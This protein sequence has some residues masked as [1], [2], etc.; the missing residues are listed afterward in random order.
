MSD[1]FIEFE[2]EEVNLSIPD[3]FERQVFR[4]PDRIAVRTRKARLSYAKLNGLANSIAHLVISRGNE[5]NEPVALL[6]E[7]DA[8]LIAAIIGVLKAGR[9]YVPLDPS[10][11]ADRLAYMRDDSCATLILTDAKNFP[12]ASHLAGSSPLVNIDDISSHFSSENPGLSI[13]PD[14]IAYILYTSGSTG[15][16]KGV[17]QYHRNVLHNIMKYTNGLR[18]SPDD[19]L[20]LLYSCSLGASVSD[21]YGALLNGAGLFPFDLKEEGLHQLPDWLMKEDIT[22]YHSVPTVFRHFVSALNGNERFPRLRM[23]KLGGESV[24]KRDWDLYKKH[25]SEKCILHVGLGSTEMN[26]TRQFFC[27]HQTALSNDIVPVGYEVKDTEVLLLNENGEEVGSDREGEIAIRSQ[28][29]PPGYWRKPELTDALF[30]P[31]PKGGKERIYL[32]GDRGCMD[33]NGCLTILGRKDSQL[34]IRGYRVEPAEVEMALMELDGVNAAVV[35]GLENIRGDKR[36]VAYVVMQ[37]GPVCTISELRRSLKRKLPDYMIPSDVVLME[38]LPLTPNGKIDRKKLPKPERKRAELDTVFVAPRDELE[39]LIA[40]ICEEILDIHPV[41]VKDDLNDLGVDSILYFNLVLEIEKICGRSLP[42]DTFPRATTVEDLSKVF[43]TEEMPAPFAV[44]VTSI[45]EGSISAG[46]VLSVKKKIRKFVKSVFLYACVIM[47]PYATGVKF[48]SWYCAQQWVQKIFFRKR[49]RC[50]RQVLPYI[51]TPFKEADAISTSLLGNVFQR[52][53]YGA[54]AH[55]SP[56]EFD[57]WV[58]VTGMTTLQSL[59]RKNRGI[60]LVL[61]HLAIE[62]LTRLILYRSGF[63]DILIFSA[64]L[65]PAIPK[66]LGLTRSKQIVLGLKNDNRFFIRHLATAK[67]VLDRSGIVLIAGDGRQGGSGINIP[68]HGRLLSFK[69]GFAELAISSG[70]DVVPAFVSMDTAGHI[71]VKFLD[72]LNKDMPETSH[73][74]KVE[75]LIRRYVDLLEKN[76]TVDPGNIR[77]SRLSRF[78][79]SP[80]A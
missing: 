49:V 41:G 67:K 5:V 51:N 18:I 71:T 19:R 70:A 15:Q 80:T 36:L 76:W 34:K 42:L 75:F 2:K 68:F 69:A 56:R 28:Y 27:D 24:Y 58:T 17:F 30:L 22:I 29:L 54:L 59:H 53:I 10:F 39:T 9:P 77:F 64:R 32:T 26:I 1:H 11:A 79:S 4:Y 8:L 33:R 13:S 16:P 48:L 78:L 6:L 55:S 3:R 66:I 38:S 52:W 61:S 23:I 37:D 45:S 35:A 14:S 12:L 25:F 31:D 43:R 62:H 7:Q 21:I 44:P 20:T 57:R 73:R 63:D 50:L 47:F 40:N 72:P 65:N 60:I 74:E 46:H